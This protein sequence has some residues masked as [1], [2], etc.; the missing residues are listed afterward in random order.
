MIDGYVY[1]D[2]IEVGEF[3]RRLTYER[4]ARR[5]QH[6]MIELDRAHQDK[7]IA[8]H[9]Y[10]R[11]LRFYMRCGIRFV[12]LDADVDGPAVWPQFAF[13]LVD[14]NHKAMLLRIMREHEIDNLPS[15]PRGLFTPDVAAI[16]APADPPDEEQLGL[17]MLKELR[18]RADRPLPMILDL[19]NPDQ[20]ALLRAGG[21]LEPIGAP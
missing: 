18:I 6:V 12:H 16:E 1:H 15:D 2:V 5:A 19:Q 4:G 9:H 20:L 11:A 21:I 13:D 17:R 7:D 10:R 8:K 14:R 3:K